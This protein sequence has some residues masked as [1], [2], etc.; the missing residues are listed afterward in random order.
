MT[1][2]ISTTDTAKLIRQALA[3]AFPGMKFSVKS[4]SYSGGSSISISW[5]DGPTS[6]EVEAVAGNFEGASFD[7]MIDLKSYHESE[8]NGETVRFGADFVHCNRN[9]SAQALATILAEYQAYWGD[10]SGS[11]KMYGWGASVE[12]EGWEYERRE[13]FWRMQSA[14]SFYVH[15]ETAQRAAM[16]AELMQAYRDC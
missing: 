15:P 11:V 9:Y 5:I 4:K 14:R 2:Y 6:K 10:N 13:R 7:G 16:E 8:L 12:F 3:A 1:R